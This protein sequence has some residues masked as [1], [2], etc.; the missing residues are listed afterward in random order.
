MPDLRTTLAAI[1]VLGLAV[2]AAGCK[3]Y[4]EKGEK[5]MEPKPAAAQQQNC[6]PANMLGT[7]ALQIAGAPNDSFRISLICG[8][9]V[10]SSCTAT[11]PA[12]GNAA[13]CAAGPN[14]VPV[15]LFQCSVG[16]GNANTAA[17]R[18]VASGC[19]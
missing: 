10:V 9:Q 4:W 3:P 16:P 18:V 15:G 11:V 14:P 5:K 19:G 8:G 6:N 1:A 17:A 13:R 2:A 7:V 12:G